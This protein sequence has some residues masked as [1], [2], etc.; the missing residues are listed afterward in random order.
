MPPQTYLSARGHTMSAITG[1]IWRVFFDE[2][3]VKSRCSSL[4]R[5][6]MPALRCKRFPT[7]SNSSTPSPELASRH[8][9]NTQL[10][11]ANHQRRPRYRPAGWSSLRRLVLTSQAVVPGRS[12]AAARTDFP[13]SQKWAV[14][15][16]TS[17]RDS[18]CRM[19]LHLPD[20]RAGPGRR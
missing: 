11:P 14:V 2:H 20:A 3:A 13:P 12:A 17:R 18:P 16:S 19:P 1:V 10:A 5:H 4:F 15:F 7:V 8:T 9:G 6:H